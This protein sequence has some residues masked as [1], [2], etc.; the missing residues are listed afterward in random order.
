M[1]IGK[2]LQ[3]WIQHRRHS[4]CP[5]SSFDIAGSSFVRFR[6]PVPLQVPGGFESFIASSQGGVREGR[7]GAYVLEQLEVGIC[8]TESIVSR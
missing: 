3:R 6:C 1:C 2:C 4:P 5:Q 8:T 7:S